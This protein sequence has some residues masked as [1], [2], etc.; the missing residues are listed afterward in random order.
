[1]RGALA[2]VIAL[3]CIGCSDRCPRGPTT[4]CWCP[5]DVIGQS[6]CG[7]D[8][9]YG[10]C[11]CPGS[12]AIVPMPSV[13]PPPPPTSAPTLVPIPSGADPP[14]GT[15]S[16][17]ID[18]DRDARIAAWIAGPVTGHDNRMAAMRRVAIRGADGAYTI[19]I[20]NQFGFRCDVDFDAAGDPS[21]LRDCRAGEAGWTA[22][23]ATIAVTCTSDA[24]TIECQAPY[25]LGARDG[26]ARNEIIL[27][28]RAA[29]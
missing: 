17:S 10:P 22:R 21:A 11:A 19:R 6:T 2:L 12:T 23:P 7:D 28:R 4:T 24:R 26:F 9:L 29:S 3:A 20:D 18:V 14:I 1:M 25:R 8:G 27:F 15:G 16:S 5:G 13:V